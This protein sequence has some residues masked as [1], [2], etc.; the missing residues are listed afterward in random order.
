MPI[1]I[2]YR[3]IST[4]LRNDDVLIRWS[5]HWRQPSHWVYTL[6]RFDYQRR[7]KFFLATST[8]PIRYFCYLIVRRRTRALF[9]IRRLITLPLTYYR[10]TTTIY[11]VY[12][13][14]QGVIWVYVYV[15]VCAY[16]VQQRE[17][18]HTGARARTFVGPVL[19]SSV[20]YQ[21]RERRRRST[22]PR[23]NDLRGVH[24][25]SRI[26]SV[27]TLARYRHLTTPPPAVS[28]THTRC[29]FFHV[30]RTHSVTDYRTP[31]KRLASYQSI[32]RRRFVLL[33]LRFK[34]PNIYINNR[35]NIFRDINDETEIDRR[36]R[37]TPPF[38]VFRRRAAVAL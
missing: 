10:I 22:P 37:W 16:C 9:P 34:T 3:K 30:V 8:R 28:T 4:L 7:A 27:A 11:Y 31:E 1:V 29:R 14:R 12:Y 25:L 5:N 23:W 15:W 36:F 6:A 13:D 21:F 38:A 26:D 33:R 35:R 17:N 24:R 32:D 2:K 18:E 19:S 20:F